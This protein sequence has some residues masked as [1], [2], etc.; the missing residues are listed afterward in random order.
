MVSRSPV[1]VL[2]PRRILFHHVAISGALDVDSLDVNERNW[3]SCFDISSAVV[4][5]FGGYHIIRAVQGTGSLTCARG[6]QQVRKYAP[7]ALRLAH[8]SG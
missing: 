4:P 5:L 1:L 2:V 6:V 3:L 8:A 7:S